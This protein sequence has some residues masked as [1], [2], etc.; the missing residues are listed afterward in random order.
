LAR[1]K[2][3]YFIIS[4][5]SKLGGEVCDADWRKKVKSWVLSESTDEAGKKKGAHSS[6]F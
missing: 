2:L 3:L 4:R 1:N 6:S 5:I